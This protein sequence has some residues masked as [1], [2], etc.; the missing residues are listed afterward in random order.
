M[1]RHVNERELRMDER[2]KALEV[3]VFGEA[4]DKE[5]QPEPQL[6]R[7]EKMRRDA[8]RVRAAREGREPAKEPELVNLNTADAEQIQTLDHV[9]PKTAEDILAHR[10]ESPFESL[11]DAAERVGGLSLEILEGNAAV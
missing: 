11:E 4:Q 8:R 9:G 5:D 1:T 2:L 3:K 6:D 7:V 10:A